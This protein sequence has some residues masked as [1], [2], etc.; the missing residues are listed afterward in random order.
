MLPRPF[1]ETAPVP[2]RPPL[3]VAH[4]IHSLGPGGAE[5]VL[6]ELADAAGAAGLELVVIA[7]SRRSGRSTRRPCGLAASRS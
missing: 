6:V 5:S 7:L 4:L 1:Q 3:R 2:D